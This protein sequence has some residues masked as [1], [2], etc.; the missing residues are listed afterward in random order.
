[1]ATFHAARPASTALRLERIGTAVIRFG[2]ALIVV[3]IGALKFA[4][5]EATAIEGLVANSPLLSWMYG[6]GSV[7]RVAAVIG[8]GEIVLGVLIAIRP[9]APRVSAVGSLGAILR[10]PTRTQ[11]RW[12][13]VGR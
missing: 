7:P 1:M 12:R 11:T 8:A 3:W 5:Y 4:A 13:S 9:F 6:I 2:L 10:P